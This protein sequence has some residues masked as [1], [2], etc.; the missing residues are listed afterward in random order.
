MSLR[1]FSIAII[2]STA[3]AISGSCYAATIAI[4][5]FI[6]DPFGND[7][8]APEWVELFNYGS[9]ST[10]IGGWTLKDNSSAVYTFP[11]GFTIPSG[12]YAVTTSN[13]ANFITRWLGG[14]DDPRVT[15]NAFTFALNNTNPGDGIYLRD[16]S[17]NLVWSVGYQIAS[18][19]GGDT[20]AANQY[21]ATFLAV[22]DFSQNNYGQ[23]P[24]AG[25]ALINRNG[26][27][28]TAVPTLGY[29]DNI[30]T[31][32]PLMYASSNSPLQMGSPLQGN[33]TVVPEPSAILLMF[34]VASGIF[35]LP[36]RR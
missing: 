5:E 33:Y 35:A 31:A 26:T 14:V 25:A 9:T 32:D 12:G 8:V 11:A 7:D 27:D 30:N 3:I 16:A 22:N 15:A 19:T 17:S 29:E 34:S 28:A 18:T 20:T 6:I 24:Q 36:R 23:P 1:S 13:R 2:F 4:T 10:D 21:R